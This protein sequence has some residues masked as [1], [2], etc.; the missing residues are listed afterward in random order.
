MAAMDELHNFLGAQ[1]PKS[2]IIQILRSHYPPHGNAHLKW[3]PQVDFLNIC[4]R[5]NSYLCRGIVYN[6]KFR[7]L[8]PGQ[9][10]AMCQP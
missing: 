8:V 5:K 6:L 1:K 4:D 7:P 3:P 9:I 2:E 10:A